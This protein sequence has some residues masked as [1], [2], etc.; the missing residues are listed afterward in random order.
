[1]KYAYQ[2]TVSISFEDVD[3]KIRST[4]AENGFGVITEIDIKKTFKEKLNIDYPRFRILGACNPEL[5]EKA[6]KM[7][8]EVAM[9]MP[10]NV[11]YWENKDSTVTLSAI[12]AE[13]QLIVTEHD[14]LIQIGKDVNI[15]LKTA[16]DRV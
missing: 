2:K 15:M 7:Q 3:S 10:C 6:L 12:D 16:I 8:S 4:L 1:M 14:D 5:A 9:L 13:Q 11:V